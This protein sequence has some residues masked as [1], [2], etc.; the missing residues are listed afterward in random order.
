MPVRLPL[1]C[2]QF[3]T[4]TQDDLAVYAQNIHDGLLAA[5]ATFPTPPILPAALQTLINN[6]T[7]A[8]TAAVLLGKENVSA[9]NKAKFDL[10]NALR[11]DASYVN[12]I[13]QGLISAG[14]SYADAQTL[15]LS[16]GY[17]L[18]KTPTPA[19][20]LPQPEVIKYYSTKPGQIYIKFKAN[21]NAKGMAIQY[22]PV[23]SPVSPFTN[24]SWPNSRV[25]LKGL[26]S[27]TTYEIL[28]YYIGAT[29]GGVQSNA[30]YQV[31]I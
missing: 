26:V 7:T 6:Y 27:G 3:N 19:G 18:S 17:D 21:R 24:T 22:R 30:I 25:T 8:L 9:K 28:G 29:P 15:I 5:I 10:K 4:F 2:T 16:T 11:A 14:T 1:A 23:T 31:C 12:Q 20:P 13:I